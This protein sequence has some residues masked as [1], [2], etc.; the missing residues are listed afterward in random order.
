MHTLE[1]IFNKIIFKKNIF[2]KK[3]WNNFQ[4]KFLKKVSKTK[5]FFEKSLTHFNQ[6]YQNKTHFNPIQ[7]TSPYFNSIQPTSSYFTHLPLPYLPP[8]QTSPNF[9]NLPKLTTCLCNMLIVNKPLSFN[10]RMKILYVWILTNK[11]LNFIN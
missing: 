4:K 10:L 1:K 2:W 3:F 5:I 8:K 9:L 6:S 11:Y 7:T